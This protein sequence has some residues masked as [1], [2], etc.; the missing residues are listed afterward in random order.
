M[1]T[2]TPRNPQREETKKRRTTL[3]GILLIIFLFLFLMTTIIL[4]ARLYRLATQDQYIVDMALGE[5]DGSIEL[6]R[7]QYESS[8]GQITVKGANTDNV[9]APGTTVTYDLHLRNN[10]EAII[11]FLMTPTAEFLTKDF[12]PVEFKIVDAYGN[13]VLGSEDTWATAEEMNE[14]SHKGTIHPGEVFTYHVTWQW[15]FDVSDTH[16]AY[17]TY[18]ATQEG[19]DYP[20]LAVG[21]KTQSSANLM[22]VKSSVHKAHLFGKDFGCC[23]C[24][25][26]LW[27]MLLVTAALLIWIYCLRKKADEQADKIAEYEDVLEMHGLLVDGE[28]VG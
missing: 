13:Y 1:T 10:D 12:V 26:L 8:A 5:P 4:G 2:Q 23:W 20:G 15:A 7:I 17:D 6:F 14:L 25:Y 9:V 16:D 19:P 22:P 28:L 3:L 24:C 27:L 18:L 21:I 11:D